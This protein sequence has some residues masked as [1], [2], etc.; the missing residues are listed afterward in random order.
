MYSLSC[1]SLCLSSANVMSLRIGLWSL[2]LIYEDPIVHVFFFPPPTLS[3][4][5]WHC[6]VFSNCIPKMKRLCNG[7]AR[8]IR[9][10]G[11]VKDDKKFRNDMNFRQLLTRTVAFS[12]HVPLCEDVIR[13]RRI[14][15]RHSAPASANVYIRTTGHP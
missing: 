5:R 1:V 14:P 3:S 2:R 12:R 15:S 4:I 6:I 8:C 7:E 11:E 13:R 9:I 10:A